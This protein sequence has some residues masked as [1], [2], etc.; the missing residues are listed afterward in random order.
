MTRIQKERFDS[1]VEYEKVSLLGHL[2]PTK[3]HVTLLYSGSWFLRPYAGSANACEGEDVHHASTATCRRNKVCC[4][5]TT[6]C[7]AG[8]ACVVKKLIPILVQP[9]SDKRKTGCICVWRSWQQF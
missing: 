9:T 7:L 2:E 8:L 4:D 1:D 5:R 3:R 6:R